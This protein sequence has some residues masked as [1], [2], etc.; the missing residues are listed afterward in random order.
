MARIVSEAPWL[1]FS[2][3]SIFLFSPVSARAKFNR[4]I[5]CKLL[6]DGLSFAGGTSAAMFT[7]DT[8]TNDPMVLIG[9]FIGLSTIFSVASGAMN[10]EAPDI[11][12]SIA[13]RAALPALGPWLGSL[14]GRACSK[15]EACVLGVSEAALGDTI[16][17]SY[18]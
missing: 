14:G 18:A 5:G 7:S 4:N 3:L 2:L 1:V 17:P 16:G 10:D 12:L 9:G 15:Y 6:A 13:G 8:G 11:A